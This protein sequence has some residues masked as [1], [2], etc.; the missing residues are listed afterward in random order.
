[1]PEC[2]DVK[3]ALASA[4][5]QQSTTPP[6]QQ[7]TSKVGKPQSDNIGESNKNICFILFI[8][9]FIYHLVDI[10]LNAYPRATDAPRARTYGNT[11]A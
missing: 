10:I 8:I 3:R 7:P 9:W 4:E 11:E 5:S 6:V 1:M 2:W